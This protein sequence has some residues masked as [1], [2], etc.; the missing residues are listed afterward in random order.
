[1]VLG[2]NLL[3][4]IS[5]IRGMLRAPPKWAL[6]CSGSHPAQR[7][8]CALD[9]SLIFS[10][11][12]IPPLQCNTINN[13]LLFAHVAAKMGLPSACSYLSWLMIQLINL[14]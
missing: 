10:L 6:C 3:P 8:M 11:K 14:S 13:M 2:V 7:F 4:A 12:V 9:P 5:V 1:M